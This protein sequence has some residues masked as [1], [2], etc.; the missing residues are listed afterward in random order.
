MQPNPRAIPVI[1]AV[2]VS[3]LVPNVMA[4]AKLSTHVYK[5]VD[6]IEI[7]ADVYAFEDSA[8]RPAVVWIHGGAL[9]MGNRAGIDSRL[10]SGV[11]D[12]GYVLISI[13]YR[14]APEAK[15]PAIIQDLEDA[16][17]W[18]RTKGPELFRIDPDRIGVCGGSAGGYLTLVS[19]HRVQ[20]RPKVLVSL[21]GYGDLVGDWY[22]K[23]SPHARHHTTKL[24]EDEARKLVGGPIVSDDRQRPARA[25]A[26]YNFC[27][28]QGIWPK[29]VSGWDPFTQRKQFEPYMPVVNVSPEYPPTFLIHGTA[30]TDVPYEQSR[31]MAGELA[32]YRVDHELISIPNGEH[33]FGGGDPAVIDNAYKSAVRFLDQYLKRPAP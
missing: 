5:Q 2:M 27:R 6:G 9:I 22:S 14:L 13:D 7:K 18:V 20:P 24:S 1:A 11:L 29:E 28:Q 4:A 25:G 23:P 31:M 26:F 8:V 17:R 12:S 32:R 33:G 3:C 15:L 16:F 30:D 21:F 19:G 10:K